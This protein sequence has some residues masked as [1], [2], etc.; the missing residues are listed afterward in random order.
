MDQYLSYSGGVES[1]TL[2]VLTKAIPIFADTGWEHQRMYEWLEEVERATGRTIVRVKNAD[3]TL[4]QY[5]EDQCFVPS[6][7]ARFCTRMFKIEPIDEFLGQRVPCELLI[8]L[9]AEEADKRTGNHGLMPGVSYS[10]PLV[11]MG[12]GRPDCLAILDRHGLRPKFPRYMRRG[13]CKGCFFKS[14]A[15]Y[16]AMAVMSPDEAD[17]V[18]DL[19]DIVQDQR[20]QRYGI[21]DGIKSLRKF[22]EQARAQELWEFASENDTEG[23][24]PSPCGVFCHR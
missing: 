13:G 3:S 10:Y 19:E 20:G 8:G 7:I 22:N 23:A 15:E 17:E 6:P 12:L 21:R 9:N 1:T 5:I 14:K 18:A 11:D 2:L 4:P 16:R 24:L